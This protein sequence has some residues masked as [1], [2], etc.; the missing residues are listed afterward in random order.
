[1]KNKVRYLFGLLLLIAGISGSMKAQQLNADSLEGVLKT[2]PR[3]EKAARLYVTLANI[4]ANSDPDKA[5]AASVTALEIAKDINSNS[6]LSMAHQTIGYLYNITGAYDKSI[7]SYKQAAL[8]TDSVKDKRNYVKCIGNIGLSHFYKGDYNMALSYL[9]IALKG[10]EEAHDKKGIAGCCMNVG[11][12]YNAQNKKILAMREYEKALKASRELNDKENIVRSLIN[13]G[14]CYSDIKNL[15]EALKAYNDAIVIAKEISF[16]GAL[17]QLYNNIGLMYESRNENDSALATYDKALQF[18]KESGDVYTIAGTYGNMGFVY[19][20]KK[21]YD[22]ALDYFF[23]TLKMVKEIGNKE[24]TVETYINIAT[25]YKELKDFEKAYDYQVLYSQT[26]D[27]MMNESSNRSLIEMETKYETEK[28]DSE[29]KILNK[30]KELQA[31]DLKHQ[32]IVL[33]SVMGGLGLMIAFVFFV[34]RSYQQKQKANRLLEAQNAE[35]NHQKDIIEEKNKDILDSIRYAKRIQ[36][37]LL[38][39][40]KYISRHLGRLK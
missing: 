10:Y 4:Y 40:D 9:L 25:T 39:T 16:Y 38:P 36:N 18:G 33:Y 19:K 24:F 1:M 3:N 21:E 27:S 22:K 6:A 17:G 2:S 26:K 12:I 14:N 7:E 28:K 32:R 8:V 15:S 23:K 30:D 20:K 29:I 13:I 37:S 35:I 34:F 5:M 11:L 31:A